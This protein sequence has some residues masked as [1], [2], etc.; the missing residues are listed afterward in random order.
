MIEINLLPHREAKRAADLRESIALLM[1]GLVLVAGLSMYM[2][3]QIGRQ[4]EQAQATVRQLES[5]IEHYRPQEAQVAV[6][7]EKKSELENKIEI[8]DG[9]D[10][11]RSGPVRMFDELSAHTPER[12]W[13]TDLKTQS[14]R[15]ALGGNSLDNGVVADFLRSL[16]TSEYFANVDLV[17]TGRGNSVNAS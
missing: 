4:V 11:A 17:K 3:G 7:K 9:L 12:L 6:F 16:A 15:V 14:G 10:R 13:I 5:D 8:I 2:R 1:L